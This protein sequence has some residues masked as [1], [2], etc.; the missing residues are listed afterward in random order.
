MFV[1]YQLSIGVDRMLRLATIV[2]FYKGIWLVKTL[3]FEV[4]VVINVKAQTDQ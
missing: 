1:Q 2:R 4:I 3:N